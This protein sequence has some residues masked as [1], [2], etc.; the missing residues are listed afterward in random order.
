MCDTLGFFSGGCGY[1]A[2]NSDRSPNEP[3][4]VEYYPAQAGLG[5]KLQATYISVPQAEHTNAVL[6]SRPAWMWGAEIGVNEHGVCIGNEAVFTK[7][8]YAGTGLTGMDLLR[9]ALERADTARDAVSL[10]IRLL[11]QYGQGGNCGFDHEFFYDNAFL[12][13]DRAEIYVLETAGG[14]WV[15]RRCDSAGISNRLSTGLDGDAYCGGMAYDFKKRHTEPVFT[16]FSGSKCRRGQTQACLAGAQ[17]VADCMRALRSH[18]T[19]CAPFRSG[20]VSSVCMHFGAMVGDHTTASM[21]VELRPKDIVVWTTG[22]SVPCV[23]LFKP[24]LF[25]ASPCAPVFVGEDASAKAYWLQT[26]QFRRGLV[27]REVPQEYYAQ[28]DALE[29]D[30]LEQAKTLAAEDFPAFSR[31]CME[32]ERQFFDRWRRYAFP[33]AS[34]SRAFLSRWEKKNAALERAQTE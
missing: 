32:Q 22:S 26:E 6:L 7:G 10:L 20:S 23:S 14:H 25:G 33:A 27:G 16:H 13:M 29:A 2:K 21:I 15:W 19:G 34:S 18:K 28:R 17:G 9:L 11:E 31:A 4:V 5:G 8:K 1:F 30:W 3:Q 12:V 24:W